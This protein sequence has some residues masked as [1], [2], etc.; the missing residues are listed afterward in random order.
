MT[1]TD[2][3]AGLAATGAAPEAATASSGSRSRPAGPDQEACVTL[4][5]FN[6][7]SPHHT[8]ALKVQGV[9]YQG[10]ILVNYNA[11]TGNIDV[12]VYDPEHG[13]WNTTTIVPPVPVQEGD[14]L[15]ARALA[16]GTV[17]VYINGDLIG[18]TNAGS[19]YVGKGGQ[20]GL[21]FMDAWHAMFDDFAG[22]D[23]PE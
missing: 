19:F 3:T 4:T 14:Q 10:T 1:L 20:I 18:T 7:Y 22:G 11:T 12:E 9:W 13:R 16:D 21:W 23:I 2:R 17:E 15:G 8:L 5:K 6:P